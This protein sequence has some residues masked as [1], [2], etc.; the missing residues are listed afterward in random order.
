M[1][2]P[3][4]DAAAP[5]EWDS[6][7]V[8][9]ATATTESFV[10]GALTAVGSFLQQ[11]PCFEG[12]VV[13]VHDGLSRES[14]AYLEALSD[15]VRLEAVSAALIERLAGLKS[16]LNLPSHS[17]AQF[18]ALEAFRLTGYRR[19]L[20]C[21]ADLLFRRPIGEIFAAGA[22]LLCCGDGPYVRGRRRNT[23]TYAETDAADGLDRTFNS[24]FLLIDERLISGRLYSELLALVSPGTLRGTDGRHTDQL[25]LNRYFAG[26]QT[27][28]GSTYNYMLVHA[29]D[30]RMLENL[31][32][33]EAKVLHFNLPTKPWELLDA[34]PARIQPKI[35][36]AYKLW[37]M[38]WLDAVVIAGQQLQ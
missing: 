10:P 33:H 31:P 6:S 21:D 24:G 25:V 37:F 13:V 17:V 28:A 23:M 3:G 30:I 18:F 35:L 5:D 29:R 9:F 16:E 15:R 4:A 14:Q 2:R 19:V 12:D 22:E 7:G 1:N 36:P 20:F 34:P 38:A 32:W 27:L 8:C 26:R 11:H